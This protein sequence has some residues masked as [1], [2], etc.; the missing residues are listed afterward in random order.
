MS[1]VICVVDRP[2]SS[3]NTSDVVLVKELAGCGGVVISLLLYITQYTTVLLL[4]NWLLDV[5]N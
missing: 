5:L 4:C 1:H 3:V 2:D